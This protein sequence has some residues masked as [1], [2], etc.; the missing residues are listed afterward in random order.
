MNRFFPLSFEPENQP[1]GAIIFQKHYAGPSTSF[2]TCPHHTISY[3]AFHPTSFPIYLFFPLVFLSLSLLFQHLFIP[4][5][6]L[7][8]HR[9][10]A[11]IAFLIFFFF[12]NISSNLNFEYDSNFCVGVFS[13][14]ELVAPCASCRVE[15]LGSLWPPSIHLA[16]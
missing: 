10:G 11:M 2:P 12:F 15:E 8:H 6:S 14:S 1:S 5:S 16:G 9:R 13:S 4:S 7:D 3:F